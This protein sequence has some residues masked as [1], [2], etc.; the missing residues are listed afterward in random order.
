MTDIP[1]VGKPRVIEIPK[2]AI[3]ATFASQQTSSPF[4]VSLSTGRI[5]GD[6][7]VRVTDIDGMELPPGEWPKAENFFLFEISP[8]GSDVIQVTDLQLQGGGEAVVGRLV[9]QFYQFQFRHKLN[10]GNMGWHE[11]NCVQWPFLVAVA[12]AGTKIRALAD[13]AGV[14][15]ASVSITITR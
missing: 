3:S 10:F 8:D 7:Y 12:P 6:L 1:H 2:L 14:T 13:C 4:N 9:A 15:L 11:G 5:F